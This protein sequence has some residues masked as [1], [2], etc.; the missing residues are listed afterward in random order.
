MTDLYRLVGPLRPAASAS[1]SA[2][3]A[4]PDRQQPGRS[5]ADRRDDA[6]TLRAAL[7]RLDQF[8][9]SGTPP[10]PDAP[11]GFYLNIVV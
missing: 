1:E 6:A 2:I 9:K 5:A 10:R 11:K 7:D 4:T 8:L 3:R